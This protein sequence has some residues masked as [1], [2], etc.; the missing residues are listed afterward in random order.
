M[1]RS[2]TSPFFIVGL[3]IY[4]FDKVIPISEVISIDSPVFLDKSGKKIQV[5]KSFLILSGKD[6]VISLGNS[7]KLT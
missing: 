4:S 2:G 7:S 1:Q 3:G 5:K 6:G